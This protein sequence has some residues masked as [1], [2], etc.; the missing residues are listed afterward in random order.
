L[1][2]RLWQAL[3]ASPEQYVRELDSLVP[4]LK[5]Q[6]RW[7]SKNFEYFTNTDVPSS[8]LVI[9]AY[10]GLNP[11]VPYGMCAQASCRG[12]AAQNM[13]R[14]LGL[15]ADHV[16]L[17]DI[18]TR[19]MLHWSGTTAEK[20]Q[21]LGYVLVLRV[22]EPMIRTGVIR[23]WEG[24]ISV[25]SSCRK[26]LIPEISARAEELLAA[27]DYKPV[28]TIEGNTASLDL[29]PL[30]GQSVVYAQPLT[31][32]QKRG[33]K[34][35]LAETIGRQMYLDAAEQDIT[36]AMLDLR[37]SSAA[38]ASMFST[39]REALRA[40]NA[41]DSEAPALNTVAAWESPRS[42]EL[43]WVRNLSV[44][45]VLQLREEAG[46]ALPSFR[47]SFVRRI[48]TGNSS[49]PEIADTIAELQTEAAQMRAELDAA[50]PRLERVFRGTFGMLGMGL[51][52]YAAATGNPAIEASAAIGLMNA[53]G[54]LH[55]RGR[56][57]HKAR[58]K[59]VSSP[60]Y[61]LVKAK[62]LAEHAA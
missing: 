22:L 20:I 28:A 13:A 16:L 25:C 62:E 15:Y 42:I 31:P 46:S 9:P 32:A 33:K 18:P 24:G 40:L 4:E 43:P 27:S 45:Q 35:S 58:E 11:L 49:P 21:L 23:F 2:E 39:R 8:S 53:L 19:H 57:E 54:Y 14:T 44:A 37:F 30:Y 5:R 12:L 29:A 48:T 6:A 36:G 47:D 7:T 38:H 59:L 26:K 55:G 51:A 56:D 1:D 34:R 52:V 41:F 50:R 17:P 61:V 10:G 3:Q 60:A